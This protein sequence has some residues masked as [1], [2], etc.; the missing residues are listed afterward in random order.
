M[1]CLLSN[2]VIGEEAGTWQKLSPSLGFADSEANSV[3]LQILAQ[4]SLCR[5]EKESKQ[6][7]NLASQRGKVPCPNSHSNSVASGYWDHIPIPLLR[8]ISPAA[9]ILFE[10]SK[11]LDAYGLSH[12]G[13]WGRYF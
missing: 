8:A 7:K 2:K 3:S 6:T 4:S 10:L 13:L 9:D 11:A 12:A 1:K 5:I